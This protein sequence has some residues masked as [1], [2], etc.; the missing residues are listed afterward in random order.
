MAAMKLLAGRSHR[1]LA[2]RIGIYLQVPLCEINISDFP[3]GETCV[4][5][6]ENIHG[7]DVFLIQSMQHSANQ[8]I[9]ELLIMIDAARRASAARITAVIPFFGYSR[10]DKRDRSGVALAA[11]LLANLLTNAGANRIL[12]MDL[13][14]Q[15]ITGFFDI[16]IDHLSAASVFIPYL[17]NKDLGQL[18]IGSPDLGGMKRA[19]VYADTMNCPLALIAKRRKNHRNIDAHDTIGKVGGLHI[20]LIDDMAETGHT[21]YAA[22]KL[23]QQ[24]GAISIRAAVSH[25]VLTRAGAERVRQSGLMEFITTNSTPFCRNFGIPTTILD[26]AP[27]FGEAIRC[28]HEN[29]SIPK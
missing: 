2:E 11:K 26:I 23:L 19:T 3:N 29:R 7:K 20:M 24:K 6:M 22:T 16:P 12:T 4:Q 1:A 18:T 8:H 15:Q 17:L 10:Q 9:M 21:L 25:G 27:L 5:I 14:T 28:I 13:H